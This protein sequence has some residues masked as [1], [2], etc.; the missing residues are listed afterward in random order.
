MNGAATGMIFV[1]LSTM[2]LAQLRIQQMGNAA[3]LY[4][5]MRNL[6]GSFGIAL[7]STIIVRRAQVHQ[8]L[9]VS[10]LTPFDAIYVER[11]VLVKG[12]P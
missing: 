2:S 7:V 9:M 3:G 8:A 12:A 10:H 6:G 1:P 11:L 5:L 4:N